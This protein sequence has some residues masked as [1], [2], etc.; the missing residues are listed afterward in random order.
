MIKTWVELGGG[1][2]NGE[3]YRSISDG[4]RRLLILGVY[5]L[6]VLGVQASQGK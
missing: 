2:E 6:G 5:T 4:G 1:G 3:V